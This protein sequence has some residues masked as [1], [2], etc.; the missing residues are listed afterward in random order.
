[1]RLR[2]FF[3]LLG[4]GSTEEEGG[5]W[6]GSKTGARLV[7]NRSI[8]W[9]GVRR[10]VGLLYGVTL[11]CACSIG[12]IDGGRDVSMGNSFPLWSKPCMALY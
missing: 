6:V 9:W 12:K 7:I 11:A 3:F 2:V 8:V 10:N 1:V 4:F 5:G